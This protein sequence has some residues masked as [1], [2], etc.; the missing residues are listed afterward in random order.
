MKKHLFFII[1]IV[2][3]HLAVAQN[4]GIG[5][6]TPQ[7]KLHVS[8]GSSVFTATGDVPSSPGPTAVSGSGRRLMWYA[9]KAAFRAGYI[10]D[11]QW[12]TSNI[13]LYSAAMGESTVASDAGA[14][15]FGVGA[16]ATGYIALA[17]GYGT[18]AS[19]GHA[20]AMGYETV[21]SGSSSTAMGENTTASGPHSTASGFNT[22][23]SG[24]S[25]TAM[26]LNSTAPGSS[27]TA[28]GSFSDASGAFSIAMGCYVSTNTQRGSVIIGDFR[29]VPTYSTAYDQMTMRFGGGYR[30]LTGTAGDG[31]ASGVTLASNG[32]SWGT[33]S[34]STRK[35][36][37]LP[38]NG[39]DFL[40]KIAALRLGSWN[41]KG[42]DKTA[43]RHYGPMAQEFF[44]AFGHDGVGVVGTDTTITTADID[45]VMMIAI[46]ALI[47]EN[48]V[49]KAKSEKLETESRAWKAEAGELTR[50]MAKLEEALENSRPILSGQKHQ[51]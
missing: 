29:L 7:A 10:T 21:A 23:A 34:D 3:A 42:Q 46:K 51:D 28:L 38:A 30:L 11:N 47:S 25:S 4:V 48:E 27:S 12:N 1:F 18:L 13:G 6:T 39:K 35:E 43:Y 44:A 31:T 33:V 41:Y 2:P 20:T 24:S 45:G 49:L 17:T 22:T 14:M 5:T 9:D 36:N 32:S 50:R 37:F 8:E 26:G 40:Q 19:G 15:A 16:R